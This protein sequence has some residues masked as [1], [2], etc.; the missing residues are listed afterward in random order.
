[1]FDVAVIL[2]VSDNST[3]VSCIG[4]IITNVP[5]CPESFVNP[6]VNVESGEAGVP[7]RFVEVVVGS[8]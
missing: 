7:I 5:T 4:L 6:S 3:T 8:I 1:M 2:G